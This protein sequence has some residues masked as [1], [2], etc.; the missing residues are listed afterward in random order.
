MS[1]QFHDIIREDKYLL[2]FINWVLIIIIASILTT[3]IAGV[4]LGAVVAIISSLIVAPMQ[5]FAPKSFIHLKDMYM[6]KG[7]SMFT[8]IGLFF[9]LVIVVLALSIGFYRDKK[10]T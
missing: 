1:A 5:E 6:Y 10:G 2:P 9:V 3:W 8:H 7:W 4:E